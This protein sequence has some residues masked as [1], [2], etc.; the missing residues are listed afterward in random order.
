MKMPKVVYTITTFD[1]PFIKEL[2]VIRE[3]EKTF[4]VRRASENSFGKRIFRKSKV[5]EDFFLFFGDAKDAG[6][7]RL[8][9]RLNAAKEKWNRASSNL[10]KMTCIHHEDCIKEEL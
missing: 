4:E 8:K 2:E 9:K 7:K 5:N 10:Y 1:T 3:T 6:I